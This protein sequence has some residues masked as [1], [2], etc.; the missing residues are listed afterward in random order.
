MVQTTYHDWEDKQLVQIAP[1]I[2]FQ[3]IRIEWAR[4]MKKTKHQQSLTVASCKMAS[5]QDNRR[6]SVV[7]SGGP[8]D[9][10]SSQWRSRSQC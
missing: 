1:Q 4:R 6:T 3:G 2:V 10:I 7:A 5:T 9:Q 8:D